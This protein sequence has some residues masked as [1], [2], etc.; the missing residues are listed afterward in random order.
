MLQEQFEDPPRSL[1]NCNFRANSRHRGRSEDRP[2]GKVP[3]T[4]WRSK[5]NRSKQEETQGR[6]IARKEFQK[7]FEGSTIKR[8]ERFRMV[9]DRH[10]RY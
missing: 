8:Y 4:D 7:S 1:Y 5:G 2:K 3:I 10:A 9:D 6:D